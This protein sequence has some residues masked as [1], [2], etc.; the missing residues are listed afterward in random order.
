MIVERLIAIAPTA[1]G[2]SIP[3]VAEHRDRVTLVT[4]VRRVR[5]D[6]SATRV[7]CGTQIAGG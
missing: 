7:R 1:I 6:Q 2:R 3:H 5:A 4:V